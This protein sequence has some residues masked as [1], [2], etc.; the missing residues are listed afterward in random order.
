MPRAMAN[1]ESP[2]NTASEESRDR[3][4]IHTVNPA[5]VRAVAAPKRLIAQR[6]EPN[7][8]LA[9]ATPGN[10]PWESPSA[11]SVIRRN[12]KKTPKGQEEMDRRKQANIPL[13]RASPMIIEP[14]PNKTWTARAPYALVSFPLL[15]IIYELSLS[16]HYLTT[17]REKESQ[18]FLE[19]APTLDIDRDGMK[20]ALCFRK[21][22]L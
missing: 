10:N 21:K 7:T 19:I 18:A 3:L 13:L 11:M 4:A 1:K 22:V 12:T 8:A 16:N 9:K 20:K 6:E 5:R 15:I 14:K 17:F 2:E